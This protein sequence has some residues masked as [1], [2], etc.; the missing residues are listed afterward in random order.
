MRACQWNPDHPIAEDADP[1]RIYCSA[2]CNQA[3][4][5]GRQLLRL[6]VVDRLEAY[7]KTSPEAARI[8]AALKE[9]S[10]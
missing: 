2:R 8:L 3:A 5:R 9:S 4:Y 7:A 1:R 6:D 10:Q